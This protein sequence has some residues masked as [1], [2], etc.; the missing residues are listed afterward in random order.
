MKTQTKTIVKTTI[1]GNE[2]LTVKESVKHI[3]DECMKKGNFILLTSLGYDGKESQM[4][5]R[6]SAI[7]MFK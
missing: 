1:K 5:I 6:K 7:K 4:G 2:S 3:F